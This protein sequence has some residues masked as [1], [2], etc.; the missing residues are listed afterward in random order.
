[1]HTNGPRTRQDGPERPAE[2]S[3]PRRLRRR[4]PAASAWMRLPARHLPR[5]LTLALVALY[6]PALHAEDPSGMSGLYGPY[7][8]TRESSGTSWQPDS[9]PRPGALGMQ[10]AWMAMLHGFV[11][12]IYDA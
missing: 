3:H 9:T 12:A 10:G 1:M 5:S 8:M 11:D 4:Y 2:L 6:A 7:D